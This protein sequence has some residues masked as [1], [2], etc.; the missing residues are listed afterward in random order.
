ML[1]SRGP[2]QRPELGAGGEG[3]R[4]RAPDDGEL[5][6]AVA[7]EAE[8]FRVSEGAEDATNHGL[9]GVAGAQLLPVAGAVAVALVAELVAS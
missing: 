1:S 9:G 7:A 2:Q 3:E 5:A 8:G 4:A 6:A